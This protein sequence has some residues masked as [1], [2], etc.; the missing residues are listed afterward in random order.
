MSK[1]S[2]LSEAIKRSVRDKNMVAFA[3]SGG[4][5][6][7]AATYEIIKQRRKHLTFASAGTGAP[8]LDL[9]AGAKS[10]DR[11]EVSFTMVSL[12]NVKR[13]V[14]TKQRYKLLIED[15]SNLAMSLR[16][17]AAATRMPF[18]P[19][20]SLRGSDIEKIRTF[21]G[22]E[23]MALMKSPFKDKS[24]VVVL[25][26]AAPDVGIMHA[27]YADED[28]NV[29][30]FGPEGSDGWLLRAS[31]VRI[32]TV[33]RIVPKEYVLEHKDHVFLP[34]FMVD[35]VCEA[36]YGAHPWGLVDC[37]DLDEG[38]QKDYYAKSKTQEGFDEWAQEWI[39]AMR[40]R[41]E[42]LRKLGEEKIRNITNSKYISKEEASP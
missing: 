33:E 26:P 15:Y 38:F 17:F 39:F 30:A 13:A 14:E 4:R 40:D 27:Q 23:K 21:M 2:K 25:P 11:A 3:G 20:R 22:K 36:P 12:L 6:S 5:L 42:Y 8:C 10:V 29:L 1:V 18:V 34:G 16:F 28:G 9:L 32:V 35:V 31:K 37:Y 41:S 24:Q 19:I 7:I